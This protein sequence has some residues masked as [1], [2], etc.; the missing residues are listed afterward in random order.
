MT[1]HQRGQGEGGDKPNEKGVCGRRMLLLTGSRSCSA[2]NCH[3][4]V[5]GAARA[6]RRGHPPVCHPLLLTSL[7]KT[8][9]GN[10][11]TKGTQSRH[12]HWKSLAEEDRAHRDLPSPKMEDGKTHSL[13]WQLPEGQ[14]KQHGPANRHL[15]PCEQPGTRAPSCPEPAKGHG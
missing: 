15:G 11:K 9:R 4:W 6:L 10:R 5:R 8:Q 1:D 3:L 7:D 2:V 13:H 14:L 12:V